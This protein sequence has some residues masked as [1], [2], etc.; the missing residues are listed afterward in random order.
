MTVAA[1]SVPALDSME[2]LNHVLACYQDACHGTQPLI[3][4]KRLPPAARCNC[5][6]TLAILERVA[7]SELL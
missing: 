5:A 4:V 1:R 2:H 6:E 7:S 3:A